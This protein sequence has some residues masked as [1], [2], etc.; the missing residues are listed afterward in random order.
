[1]RAPSGPSDCAPDAAVPLAKPTWER[2]TGARPRY[3]RA[4]R[5][6][7]HPPPASDVFDLFPIPLQRVRRVLEPALVQALVQH[8]TAVA[9]RPNSR[10]EQLA[11]TELAAPERHALFQQA[12]ALIVPRLVEFG[13]LLLGERLDWFIKEIWVNVLDTGGQ[14]SLHNHANSL[15]SGIVYLTESH[16]SANTVFIKAAGGSEFVFNNTNARAKLGPYNA[17][18]WV[19]PDPAPGDLLLFPSYLL[20]EVPANRGGRRISLAFNAIPRRL[21]SWGYTLSLGR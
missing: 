2:D 15:V 10:S 9:E 7:D 5:A 6:M 12:D 13:E 3:I 20:H 11:H 18:K 1:M 19:S 4:S 14:Q 21:D 17:H 16:P 8:F